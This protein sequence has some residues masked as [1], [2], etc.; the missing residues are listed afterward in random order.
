MHAC[1]AQRRPGTGGYCSPKPRS[2]P[3]RA[4]SG[5]A[6]APHSEHSRIPQGARLRPA[7]GS[8]AAPVLRP[9]PLR[10]RRHARRRPGRDRGRR[11]SPAPSRTAAVAPA[12]YCLSIELFDS[13]PSPCCCWSRHGQLA[14]WAKYLQPSL[15]SRERSWVLF[16]GT[17]S[18]SVWQTGASVAAP[19]SPS[20]LRQTNSFGANTTGGT[21]STRNAT[22][23]RTWQPERK[24]SGS[25][26]RHSRPF[27]SSACSYPITTCMHGQSK[28]SG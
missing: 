12:A 19:S 6:A 10:S 14:V 27:T 28:P 26:A 21:A 15:Q 9:A 4:G 18:R 25:A 7:P 3:L 11:P 2:K 20:L 1:H 16:W 5:S 17:G 24:P 13:D 22:V 23:R 8:E